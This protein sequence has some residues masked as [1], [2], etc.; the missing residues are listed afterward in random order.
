[1][2][3]FD[4]KQRATAEDLCKTPAINE[5]L[6]QNGLPGPDLSYVLTSARLINVSDNLFQILSK[7]NECGKKSAAKFKILS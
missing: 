1:M 5:Y 7:V 6:R 2:L 4:P 3:I